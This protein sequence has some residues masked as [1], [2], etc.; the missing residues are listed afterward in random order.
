MTNSTIAGNSRLGGGVYNF[1]GTLTVTNS[2]IAGNTG[3]AGGGVVNIAGTLTVTNSTIA[4]N[5][6]AEEITAAAAWPTTGTLTVTNST[7]TG[8]SATLGGGVYNPA[9]SP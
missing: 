2:T 9:P 4:G 1:G 6:R 5:A 7:I 3:C 8:N